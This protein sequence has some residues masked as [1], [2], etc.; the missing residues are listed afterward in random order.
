MST[1]NPCF[2]AKIKNNLYP[3]WASSTSTSM[4]W[5]SMGFYGSV[6]MLKTFIFLVYTASCVFI[7]SVYTASCVF[8][9]SVYT[10]SCVFIFSVYTASCVFIFSVYTAS[11]V[12]ELTGNGRRCFTSVVRVYTTVGMGSPIPRRRG[13]RLLL[14]SPAVEMTS[15]G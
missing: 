6:M 1:H 11:C 15:F 10:A 8:I 7:F 14:L 12:C 3:C 13:S 2:R 4:K 9:F 5:D